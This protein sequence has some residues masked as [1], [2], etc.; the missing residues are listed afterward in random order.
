MTFAPGSFSRFVVGGGINT[1]V[2]YVLFL[3]L[4]GLMHHAIAY[5]LS[6]AF[7]VLLSYLINALYVF[8]AGLNRREALQFPIAYAVQYVFG[9]VLLSLLVDIAGV[10]RPTAMLVVIGAGVVLSFF[11]TKR[12]FGARPAA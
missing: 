6:Y 2:T 9:L 3:L 5:T 7:G 8:K 1:L 12:I 4:A 10:S 11:L